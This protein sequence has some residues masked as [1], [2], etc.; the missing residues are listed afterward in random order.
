MDRGMP[1]AAAR[2]FLALSTAASLAACA[3][4]Q[5]N[6]S[7]PDLSERSAAPS[8]THCTISSRL[9]PS[10]GA[11]WGVTP[12]IGTRQAPTPVVR[13]YERRIGRPVAVF[14]A[15]PQGAQLFP[16]PAEIALP[17]GTG[18]NRRMLVLNWKPDVG[19]TWRQ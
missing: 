7:L 15:Y 3:A 4:G 2:A 12:T 6:D 8:K 16:T 1:I 17:R 9:V 13:D 10:C 11:W 14:P 19:K 18:K 5:G